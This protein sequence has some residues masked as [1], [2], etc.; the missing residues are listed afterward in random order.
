VPTPQAAPAVHVPII[1]S[2]AELQISIC[3]SLQPRFHAATQKAASAGEMLKC[4]ASSLPS[5]ESYDEFWAACWR[6]L[7]DA[8]VSV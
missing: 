7:H 8:S 2:F 1:D 4:T 6:V 5:S 3:V